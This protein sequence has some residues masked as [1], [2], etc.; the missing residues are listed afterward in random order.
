[1]TPAVTPTSPATAG[2]TAGPTSAYS[3]SYENW[4]LPPDPPSVTRT[5]GRPDVPE[6]DGQPGGGYT[7]PA[8]SWDP[9]SVQAVKDHALATLLAWIG[10][11]RDPDTWFTRVEPY[12]TDDFGMLAAY[13]NPENIVATKVTG[14]PV[15]TDDASAYVG[16]VTIPTDDGPYTLTMVRWDALSAWMC[17][18]ITR[19][20]NRTPTP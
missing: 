6:V 4:T 1:M 12:L 7:G 10:P 11:D 2:V 14:A 16:K 9:G 17:D 13:R 3:G 8:P 19:E 15:I 20:R 5:T 18:S